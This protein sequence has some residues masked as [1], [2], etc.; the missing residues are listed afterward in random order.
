MRGE[1]RLQ[2]VPALWDKFIRPLTRG[3][4]T[5]IIGAWLLP[6]AV[7]WL[8]SVTLDVLFPDAGT[9]L[10]AVA[11]SPRIPYNGVVRS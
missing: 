2:T 1:K 11:R 8:L 3:G 7:W 10:S 6:A 9:P 4:A 5:V